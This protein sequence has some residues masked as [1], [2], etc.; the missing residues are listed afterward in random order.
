VLTVAEASKAIATAMPA[1]GTT[2][3][4]LNLATG[5]ILHQ[6]VCA[7]RDQPPFDRVTMDGIAIRY[8]SF[9]SGNRQ[10][11][12]QSRQHAGEQRHTLS[13]DDECIEIM[14]GAVLPG[15][16][17]C[18][19]PVERIH[20]EAGVAT[21]E[22]AYGAN[23]HQFIHPQ[24]SDHRNGH[25]ILCAGHRIEAVDIAIVASCGLSS[26]RVGKQPKIQVISTGNELVAAGLPVDAHQVR[27]SNGPAL[28][29]MLESH[30]Y[31]SCRHDH[32]ADDRDV[33]EQRLAQ[34]LQ[35]SNV[36]ILSGGVSMGKADF[37]PEVL[38]RLGVKVVFHKISQRPGKPMWFGIGPEDQAVFALPG[39]P[40]STLICCRHYVLPALARASR[41]QVP[42]PEIAVLA[43]TY[44]FKPTLS[45]LLPVRLH[46]S[47]DGQLLATPVATNTSGDFAAL[48][49]TDGYIELPEDEQ[50]FAAGSAW[51]LHR[52]RD[53]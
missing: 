10:F 18:I 2:E 19:I 22:P 13:N 51:P 30:G 9:D 4:S 29:A 27:M 39:N 5:R 21:I 23:Q 20:V 48:S 46:N 34:H 26:V 16:T 17:D 40:V 50:E 44:V 41:R 32:I 37:V 7:E 33:L 11:R 42:S 25:Q 43:E 49:G 38:T 24:G 28:I 52:W 15:N 31:T 14:T 1:F 36:L 53:L 45:C 8:S 6:P 35:E 3:V 12:I 47:V